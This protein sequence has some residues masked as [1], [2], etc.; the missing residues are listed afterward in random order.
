MST[1]QCPIC[2]Q[3][4]LKKEVKNKVFEY[5]GAGITIS[6]Y[7]VYRCNACKDAI[8]D[9]D[10]LKTSGHILKSFKHEVDERRL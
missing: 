3:G 7:I 9:N 1:S 8:V 2:G 4:I 6:D 5:A 10:T